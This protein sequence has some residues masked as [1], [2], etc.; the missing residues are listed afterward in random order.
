MEHL[1][2]RLKA[3]LADR[4]TIERELGSGGMAVVY[5]AH[6]LKLSRHVALKVLRPELA[7]SLGAERFL[8]EI[9]I[10][11]KL[12]H[13]N[14]LSLHDCGEA[15][16]F[17]YYVMPFVEGE[18][19]RDKLNS[20][21]RLSVEDALQLTREMCDGL[22]YAHEQG[23]VH[24]DIKPE[25]ILLSQGHVLIADF[26]IARAVSAAGGARLTA[27]GTSIGTPLYM[28]PEQAGGDQSVD[29][30]SDLYSVGC[31]LYEMLAGEPPF[32]GPNVQAIMAKHAMEPVPRVT[33]IRPTVPN[34][35]EATIQ[36]AMEKLPQDRFS[37][38]SEL[39]AHLLPPRGALAPRLR[40]RAAFLAVSAAVAVLAVIV[41]AMLLPR[42]AAGMFNPRRV[43]VAP[44]ENLTGEESLDMLGL[45]V[46]SWITDG[47]Q[48]VDM[49]SVV[50]WLAVQ[51]EANAIEG[52]N[53]LRELAEVTR[54]GIVVSG[55]YSRVGDSLR[56]RAAI[57]D[58]HRM[59]VQQRFPP[60]SGLPGNPEA[61]FVELGDRITGA[62]AVM[63]DTVAP[64]FSP[65]LLSQP[66]FAA[67][68]EYVTGIDLYAR[69]RPYEAIGH[70]AMAYELDTTFV[71]VLLYAA[72]AHKA[73]RQ[74][75]EV[76]SLAGIVARSR[77]LLST[78]DRQW[79]AYF[80]A[81]QQ[82]N[83]LEALRISRAL[84]QQSPNWVGAAALNAIY[85]NRP[86]QAIEELERTDPNKGSVKT[87]G[88]YWS[89]LTWARHMLGDHRR[90]LRDAR[91]GREQHPDLRGT[92]Y[93]EVRALAALGRTDEVRLLLDEL[94]NLPPSV[95]WGQ[96]EEAAYA[97]LELRAHGDV[98]AA[99]EVLGIALDQL[100]AH[101]PNEAQGGAYRYSLAQTL[102]WAEQWQ[103]AGDIV[104]QLATENPDNVDYVGYLGVV[105]ARLGNTAEAS[106]ISNEL[107][108]LDR[109]Y[110]WG[111]NTC[112]RARIAAV[113]GDRE[114]SVELLRQ[115]FNEGLTNGNYDVSFHT[116]TDFEVLRDHPQFQ[117]LTRP[118][119]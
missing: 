48:R 17:L 38:A 2:E 1:L 83:R 5:L 119:G 70:F 15:H 89:V 97:G 100:R 51:Q 11:A 102:Y 65:P 69:G 57:T 56:F 45:V 101:S 62:L 4:Y 114:R 53:T 75:A 30:R 80:Q 42:G 115:A 9:E 18:S 24:R 7:A 60:V 72:S 12:T 20:E 3:A 52:G 32:T 110:L 47:L 40:M 14:I 68:R 76:D 28:S 82:G 21:T 84:A 29:H 54:A 64:G 59:E 105:Y 108:A 73:L 96:A 104:L 34:A 103:E 25:N 43:V 85:T 81:T 88:W 107:A 49:L 117:E 92:L 79:L 98:D 46:A 31:V 35:V 41:V 78:Y 90:E 33:T 58:P 111:A 50:P 87:L 61:A 118:K 39:S 6:D 71:T 16:G 8:R 26:G 63:L 116:D 36:Q 55:S 112:W 95:I 27:T 22:G 109:P 113:L 37:S 94:A 86:R 10:A 67:Y 91:R 74:Q 19:L 23:I 13:P 93:N 66:M 106:R 44:F 77:D 99:R